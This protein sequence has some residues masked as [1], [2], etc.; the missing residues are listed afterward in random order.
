MFNISDWV[1]FAGSANQRQ[2]LHLI[3]VLKKLF[4]IV[5][6]LT[7]AEEIQFSSCGVNEQSAILN[8]NQ[9]PT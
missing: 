7:T 3:P 8:F 4:I 6:R 1:D 9:V 5:T 2:T